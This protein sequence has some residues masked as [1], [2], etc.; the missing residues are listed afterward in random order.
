M[1]SGTSRPTATAP[2]PRTRCTERARVSWEPSHRPPPRWSR[3][4]TASTKRFPTPLATSSTATRCVCKWVWKKGPTSPPP[5]NFPGRHHDDPSS[6]FQEFFLPPCAPHHRA[7]TLPWPVPRCTRTW[8]RI[9]S[10]ALLGSSRPESTPGTL[11]ASVSD[12]EGT[13]AGARTAWGGK[14][15][16]GKGGTPGDCGG[17]ESQACVPMLATSLF[18][19]PLLSL[20]SCPASF[21]VSPTPF[22]LARRLASPGGPRAGAAKALRLGQGPVAGMVSTEACPTASFLTAPHPPHAD[23]SDLGPR[24]PWRRRWRARQ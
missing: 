16:W 7:S 18:Y 5:K 3:N 13:E 12:R 2:R 6:S 21:V 8:T 19:T 11:S 4:A 10:R 22:C 9:S 17:G 20:R 23:A 15:P 24:Q 14:R 1:P